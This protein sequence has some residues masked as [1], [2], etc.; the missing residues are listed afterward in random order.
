MSD[1][2]LIFVDRGRETCEAFRWEFR[3]HPEVEIVCGKFE[4][5]STFDCVVTAGNSFGLMDAGMDLAVVKFFGRHVMERIQKVILEDH[6][7]EQPVGT[8]VLVPT[9]DVKHPFVAHAP[10]MRTP[11]NIQ[12]TDHVYLALW[13]AL[14]AVH[15][16]NRGEGRKIYSV[17]CP[18]LGT[19]TGGMNALEAALQMRLAYEYFRKPAQF[20]NPSM[21]QERQERVYYGGRW[22][23]G[24]PRTPQA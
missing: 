8:C 11:M 23:F 22:G 17:A 13:A 6:L 18:G 2:R 1:V 12:G 15:R 3:V 4:E 9:D 19:G 20:I 24:N 7:G 16:H 10:T 14:T 21:A 5:L